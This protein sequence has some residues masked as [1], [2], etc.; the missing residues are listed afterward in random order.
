MGRPDETDDEA[1]DRMWRARYGQPLPVKG[2]A[3]IAWKI[4]T[5]WMLL[6][7]PEE[8]AEPDQASTTVIDWPATPPSTQGR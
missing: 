5:D 2:S 8:P 7:D 1:I 6:T 4:L 3:D